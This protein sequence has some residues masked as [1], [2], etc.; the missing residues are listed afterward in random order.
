M[1]QALTG[2]LQVTLAI[3]DRVTDAMEEAAGV[4]LRQRLQHVE[5]LITHGEPVIGL[6]NLCSNLYEFDVPLH[7]GD[8]E[9]IEVAGQ[10]LKLPADTW[11]VLTDQVTPD[12]E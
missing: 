8:Y 6:E 12:S 5:E 7:A 9:R 4:P 2:L 1:D 3:R 10:A 11:T